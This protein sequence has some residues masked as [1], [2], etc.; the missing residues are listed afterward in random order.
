MS[1]RRRWGERRSRRA[2][3]WVGADKAE[4]WRINLS[5][6]CFRASVVEGQALCFGAL[7]VV[8]NIQTLC[9]QSPHTG[10]Q[11]SH[12]NTYAYMNTYACCSISDL[13]LTSYFCLSEK[14]DR[15]ASHC[16][17]YLFFHGYV[18]YM[19]DI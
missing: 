9:L 5:R 8:S 17:L 1:E 11:H 19:D 18:I 6:V 4:L 3:G 10:K 15:S 2:V 16:Y 7:E 12:Q 14:I 13:V